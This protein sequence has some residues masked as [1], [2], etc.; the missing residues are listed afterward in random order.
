MTIDPDVDVTHD[1]LLNKTVAITQPKTGYRVGTDAILLAA[2]VPQQ[3][4]RILDMGC[5]VGGVALCIARRL[6]DVLVA[7]T[8]KPDAHLTNVHITAIEIDP[9]MVA[10]A[11]QN[12]IDNELG[13]YIRLLKGDITA[14]S[15]V[16]ANSFDHVVSNP[17]YHD[18]RGTRPQN[19]SRA[20]AHMGE[21]T[22]LADWV[23]A[24]I[25][26]TKPRGRISFIC[27]AD[28]ASE[29]ITAF[30]SNGAGETLLCPLWP[31]HDAPASR[32]IIQ[33]RKNITGPGAILPGLVLHNDLG[34]YTQSASHIMQGGALYLAHPARS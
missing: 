14:M 9:D 25:W 33:V 2:S 10:L 5:G 23:K 20:L 16:L 8:Q 13:A 6:C 27:R 15:P 18:T 30:E 4:K 19:R 21:D 34:G 24:A 11:E 3:T 7:K 17:P 26:A 1:H 28:R 22:K 12:I 29:L 32:V 31:R